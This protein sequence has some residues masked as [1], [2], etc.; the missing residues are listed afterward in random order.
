MPVGLK[1]IPS[2]LHSPRAQELAETEVEAAQKRQ[3]GTRSRCS[4][5]S[6]TYC[7]SSGGILCCFASATFCFC[8]FCSFSFLS[9]CLTLRLLFSLFLLSSS[10]GFYGFEAGNLRWRQR[11]QQRQRQ[12]LCFWQPEESLR[13]AVSGAV[14]ACV[15]LPRFKDIQQLGTCL[16]L[17][18]AFHSVCLC[19]RRWHAEVKWLIIKS[20]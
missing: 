12:R 13:V 14:G 17:P 5:G 15:R 4:R 1:D 8:I 11:Q 18:L 6:R 3:L 16:G 2:Y 7:C 20:R 10:W 19:V 9:F